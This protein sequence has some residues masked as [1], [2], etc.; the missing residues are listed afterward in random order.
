MFMDLPPFF[1]GS[2]IYALKWRKVKLYMHM[3]LAMHANRYSIFNYSYYFIFSIYSFSFLNLERYIY[4]IMADKI[5][6]IM[7]V[8][9]HPGRVHATCFICT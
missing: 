9:L 3:V 5:L 2:D 8:Y 6:E 4:C 1:K 7:A